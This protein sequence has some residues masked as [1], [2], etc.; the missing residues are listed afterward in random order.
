LRQVVALHGIFARLD[1]CGVHF[2]ITPNCAKA[3]F[4]QCGNRLPRNK[5]ESATTTYCRGWVRQAPAWRDPKH[6]PFKCFQTDNRQS[7]AVSSPF[8]ALR[9]VTPC[10]TKVFTFLFH[11]GIPQNNWMET[12]Q[13]FAMSARALNHAS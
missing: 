11:V 6:P 12:A 13:N 10:Y 3:S 2:Q 8:R 4:R 1:I 7:P 5:N 9:F